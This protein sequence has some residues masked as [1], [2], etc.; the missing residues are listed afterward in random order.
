[1]YLADGAQQRGGAE[2]GQSDRD[3]LAGRVFD[4]LPAMIGPSRAPRTRPSP[5]P[6]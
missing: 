2:Q 1:M 6:A 4:E 5:K 3:D